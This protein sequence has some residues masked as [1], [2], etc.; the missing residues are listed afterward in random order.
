MV[1]LKN[2]LFHTAVQQCKINPYTLDKIG[3]RKRQEI[4]NEMVKNK[5]NFNCNIL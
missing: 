4:G 2:A 3:E 1:S 5:Y